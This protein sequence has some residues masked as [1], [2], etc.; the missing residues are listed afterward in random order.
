L[1]IRSF[2][3]NFATIYKNIGQDKVKQLIKLL[4]SNQTIIT[5]FHD[6]FSLFFYGK[7]LF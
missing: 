6:A 2:F 1:L 4:L 7:N 5:N 3:A